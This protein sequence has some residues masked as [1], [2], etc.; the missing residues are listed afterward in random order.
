MRIAFLVLFTLTV[1]ALHG[2]Q[3]QVYTNEVVEW[4]FNSTVSYE[5]PYQ[6]VELHVLFEGPDRNEI[7]VP[8]FWAG[9]DTWKVRFSSHVPGVYQFKSICSDKKNKGLHHATGSVDIIPYQGNHPLMTK[10]GITVDENQNIHHLDGS[11]FLWLADSWWHGATTRLSWPEGFKTLTQDRVDKGFSVIQLAVGYPCDIVP[12]DPRG[13]NEAGFPTSKD[14][15]QIN[16][17]YFNLVDQR[18]MHL[19]E[20][21]LVPNILGTWGYYLP[22]FGLENM[23]SYWNY[24][25][26]RYAAYPIAWTV[27]GETTLT[28]YLTDDEEEDEVKEFQRNGW[29]EI[30]QYIKQTDPYKRIISAHPGPNSGGFKAISNTELLDIIMVQPGH[31]GWPQFSRALGHLRTAQEKFKN[32]AVMQGEVC[33]E[34]MFGGGCDAKLQ[35]QLFW[36]NMLSGASG[37]CYG[38]DAIWQFNSEDELFGASPSGHTWGNFT[39]QEAYQWKGS[40]FVGLGRKI[41]LAY[42]WQDFKSRPDWISSS[43]PEDVLSPYAAGTPEIRLLYFPKGLAPWAPKQEMIGLDESKSYLVTYVDPMTAER[44]PNATITGV[45]AWTVE[46]APILQDWLVEIKTLTE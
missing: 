12:F 45:K 38:A 43:D 3:K 22:W 18:I 5:K 20:A 2:L 7:R 42:P 44:Y 37:H 14:Y 8:G 13:A 30:A 32:Q 23:K 10:G 46:P 27:A 31:S 35:R 25:I 41:L 39:W 4:T 29:S 11:P 15:T 16:P 24:L 26:A 28:Y 34:G 9:G 17:E 40:Y 36:A 21:G 33:F 6:E 1:A 19:V